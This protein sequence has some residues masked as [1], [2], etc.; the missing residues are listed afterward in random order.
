[1]WRFFLITGTFWGMFFVGV[2]FGGNSRESSIPHVANLIKRCV[3][4]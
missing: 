3:T 1:M 2:G 4:K